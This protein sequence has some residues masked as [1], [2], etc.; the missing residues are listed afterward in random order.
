MTQPVIHILDTSL[1]D[2]D[3]GTG[4][5]FMQDEKVLVAR[6]LAEMGINVIEAGFARSRIDMQSIKD[7][8]KEVW[9]SLNSPTIA[10][11]SRWNKQDIDA[12]Y[13]ALLWAT[14]PRIHTFIATSP[15]HMSTKLHMDHEQ[16]IENI[17]DSVSYAVSTGME[18][19]WSA[20]DAMNSERDFLALAVKTAIESWAKVINIPDTLGWSNP[21]F[22][23]DL[24]QFLT[25][26]TASLRKQYN[27]IF[28]S[29]MH[30]DNGLALA[31]TIAAIHWWARQVEA[32]IL[33]IWER[34]WN[35]AL[36]QIVAYIHE[37]Q[38]LWNGE[39]RATTTLIPE[40]IFP[41][42][43][44]VSKVLWMEIKPNEPII[45]SRTNSHWSWIHADWAIKWSKESGKDIYSTINT[46]RYG[47]P[48][49]IKTFN[50]RWWRAEILE[51]LRSYNIQNVQ[52]EDIEKLIVRCAK[53]AELS[54]GIYP[55][56]I[57]AYYL[58][59]AWQFEIM[60]VDITWTHEV[61]ITVRIRDQ[62]YILHGE[63]DEEN[64]LIAA[65]V[66]AINTFLK[67]TGKFINLVHFQAEDRATIADLEKEFFNQPHLSP[68][69]P[70]EWEK[71]VGIITFDLENNRK[72]LIRTRL[73][74]QNV[75]EASI[76]ALIYWS[77][78]EIMN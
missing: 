76:K 8:V 48:W 65:T 56:L 21:W 73:S 67:K 4:T 44:L 72:E 57:Y 42:S 45:W 15:A 32:T 28:S 3:Q 63:S 50:A 77:I 34:T 64:G 19:Q 13:E 17:C 37:N 31:N 61:N 27:F 36:H 60:K 6:K 14:Y 59:I 49:E 78:Y 51:V 69:E 47:N 41:V 7:V 9:G 70:T 26:K 2:G 25:M 29:H 40:Y 23:E 53:M 5:P 1:R 43:L 71:A 46:S 22:V 24:F 52:H 54:R 12:S 74:G 33:W 35:V 68:I 58:E 62:V 11:L 20:E 66:N 30:N 16:V 38:L 75:D 18:V 55:S 10:S 39:E